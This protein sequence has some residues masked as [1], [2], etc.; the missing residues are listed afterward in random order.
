MLGFLVVAVYDF[1]GNRSN[2]ITQGPAERA[3]AA[4]VRQSVATRGS[5]RPYMVGQ[6]DLCGHGAKVA[7]WGHIPE[8]AR[9]S[10]EARY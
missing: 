4:T 7:H 9:G 1:V 6:E 8:I 3:E 5:A 10:T 2:N